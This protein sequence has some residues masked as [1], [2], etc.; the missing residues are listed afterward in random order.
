MVSNIFAFMLVIIETDCIFETMIGMCMLS[1]YCLDYSVTLYFSL[2]SI[3]V[4]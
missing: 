2:R 4:K 1:D 3:I